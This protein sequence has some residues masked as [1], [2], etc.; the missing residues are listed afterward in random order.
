MNT[1]LHQNSLMFLLALSLLLAF[2]LSGCNQEDAKVAQSDEQTEALMSEEKSASTPIDATQ[3][4]ALTDADWKKRLTDEQYHVLRE[5]GTERA[6]TG[7]YWD[8]K[9]EGVYLCVACG[10]E[11]FDSKTKYDSG[12][13]WPSYYQPINQTAVGT[14]VDKS[15]FSTRTEVHCSRCSGHLGHVFN[16]GPQPTG[17]RYCINSASLDFKERKGD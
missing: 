9:K 17:M 16:D 3:V 12:T 10:Q 2:A 4:A 6:F 1:K 8:N 7:T 11:L 5:Q 15:L 14:S 13:G